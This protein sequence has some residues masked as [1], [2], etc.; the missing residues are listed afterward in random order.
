M[1]SFASKVMEALGNIEFV[2]YHLIWENEMSYSVCGDFIDE[3]AELVNAGSIIKVLKKPNHI[4]E[5]QHFMDCCEYLGI[6]N[7][8]EI[9]NRMLVV[10]YPIANDDRHYNHF[11][12]VRNAEALEWIGMAPIFD[13][14]NSM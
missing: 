10:D 12:A 5:H 6:P 3:Y 2:A 1:K 8:K 7:A 9:I 11:G 13:C 14:G 4:S